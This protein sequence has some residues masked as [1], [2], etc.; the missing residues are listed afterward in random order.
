MPQSS[1]ATLKTPSTSTTTTTNSQKKQHQPPAKNS[2][3]SGEQ[4]KPVD[5]PCKTTTPKI[6]PPSAA[7]NK[8]KKRG[9]AVEVDSKAATPSCDFRDNN[10][11]PKQLFTSAEEKMMKDDQILKL[12]NENIELQKKNDQML[13][14][15]EEMNQK[16]DFLMKLQQRNEGTPPTSSI[17]FHANSHESDKKKSDFPSVHSIAV[18]HPAA[19]LMSSAL[20]SPVADLKMRKAQR[21]S[22]AMSPGSMI[23]ANNIQQNNLTIYHVFNQTLNGLV[24]QQALE[25]ELY[26]KRREHFD[27]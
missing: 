14:N 24:N 21:S 23:Y 20:S 18:P 6:N 27:K 5:K 8:T 1:S 22:S 4:C 15:Q 11:S 9:K 3:N 25:T 2:K 7:S 26:N 13:K 16:L 10:C 19:L 12:T 17:S